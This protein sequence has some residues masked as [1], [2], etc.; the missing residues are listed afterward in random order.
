MSM[1]N[2]NT[3]IGASYKLYV[4]ERYRFPETKIGLPAWDT[5]V[6]FRP[7]QATYNS[8][9][10][11][12]VR[13]II[14]NANIIDFRQGYLSFDL[15]IIMPPAG[16]MKLTYFRFAKYIFSIVNRFRIR[17]SSVD[18]EDVI[19]YNAIYSQLCEALLDSSVATTYGESM[20][21]GTSAQLNCIWLNRQNAGVQLLFASAVTAPGVLTYN[22]SMPIFSG[23][24]GS[25]LLPLNTISGT[26]LDIYF[27]LE[28]PVN[29]IET[30]FG[31][32]APGGLVYDGSGVNS[33]QYQLSN[34]L[35]HVSRINFDK[36]FANRISMHVKTRGFNVGF[37]SWLRFTNMISAQQQAVSFN[38]FVKKV[39]VH[40]LLH[41][42]QPL[43]YQGFTSP[44]T[45]NDKFIRFYGPGSTSDAVNNYLVTPVYQT[46]TSA[47]DAYPKDGAGGYLQFFF[48]NP[49][50]TNLQLNGKTVPDEPII[51]TSGQ[52]AGAVTLGA[53]QTG[54]N[55]YEPFNDYL[56]WCL[57]SRLDGII[58][59]KAP[60]INSSYCAVRFIQIDSFDAYPEVSDVIT[61]FNTLGESVAIIKNWTFGAFCSKPIF[62]ITWAEFFVRIRIETNG[63][64][65]KWE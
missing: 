46:T 30:D 18:I 47:S 11:N 8:S 31:N 61:D 48:L 39:S 24:L 44:S 35:L 34:I 64:V 5:N 29:C 36:E 38:I 41:T 26:P 27:F 52:L 12:Q 53:G 13:F 56:K 23:I 63:S 16:A 58:P 22:F 2:G 28:Q 59:I 55:C 21:I 51:T 20:N 65:V 54:P 49:L 1:Q 50:Q 15:S 4:P 45:I 33:I 17:A 6:K 60:I 19:D 7:E 10:S 57:K 25:Q 3:E 42:F 43:N 9:T 62:M 37:H 14:P 32:V 40:N